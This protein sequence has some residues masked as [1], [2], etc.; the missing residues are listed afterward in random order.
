[1]T[2]RMILD[3]LV[4]AF[5]GLTTTTVVTV[6]AWIRARE[7]AI[8]AESAAQHGLPGA[9]DQ[10][11]A[12]IETAIEA[13]AVEIERISEAERYAVKLLAERK[14]QDARAS[15]PSGLPRM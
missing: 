10:R 5:A 11:L 8:R 12:R 1:M 3:L 6:V 15:L 13:M 4:I 2:T 9:A 14:E 7:R